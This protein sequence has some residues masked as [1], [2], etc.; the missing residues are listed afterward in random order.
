MSEQI[1]LIIDGQSKGPFAPKQIRDG[2]KSGTVTPQ[3]LAALRGSNQWKP[4]AEVLQDLS[5]GRTEAPSATERL[6]AGL[7]QRLEEQD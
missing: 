3:S 2:L 6:L 1:F 7:A 4:V 5:D